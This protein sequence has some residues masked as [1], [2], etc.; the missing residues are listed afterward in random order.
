MMPE[1]LC[2]NCDEVVPCVVEASAGAIL[3]RCSKCY[4]VVDWL[5]VDDPELEEEMHNTRRHR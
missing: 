2:L 3:Y 5:P 1:E 4:K